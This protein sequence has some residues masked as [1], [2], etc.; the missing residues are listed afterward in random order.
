MSIR[1]AA[2]LPAGL[3]LMSVAVGVFSRW[4]IS[5]QAAS[6]LITGAGWACFSHIIYRQLVNARD[7]VE[8]NSS[9]SVC[10]RTALTAGPLAKVLVGLLFIHLSLI[11]ANS[12]FR[13]IFPWDAVTTWMYS[14]KAWVMSDSITELVYAPTWLSKVDSLGHPM[15]ASHYPQTLPKHTAALSA[16]SGVWRPLVPGLTWAA[17]WIAIILMTGGAIASASGSPPIALIGAYMMGSL[18]LLNAHAALAGYADI[19]MVLCSGGGLMML[20]VWSQ[21]K[22]PQFLYLSLMLLLAG[23][24]IKAEGWIWA[25]MG[26]VFLLHQYFLGRR[27]YILM[28]LFFGLSLASMVALDI[29]EISLGPAGFW[30]FSAD[31]IS[32]GVLGS[33]PTRPYNALPNYFVALVNEPNFHL[34]GIVYLASLLVISFKL[35]R[36]AAPFWLMSCLII[37]S[38]SII[39][40][41]SSFSEYAES[42]TAINRLLLHFVPVFVFTACMGLKLS[43]QPSKSPQSF[44]SPQ[45]TAVLAAF[46][47]LSICFLVVMHLTLSGSRTPAS[48]ASFQA[49]DMVSVLGETKMED[50]GL[51]FLK[52]NAP[53]GVLRAPSTRPSD[54]NNRIAH[55]E[56]ASDDRQHV[57]FYWIN[58]E[59]RAV[60]HSVAPG[61]A[62]NAIIDLSVEDSWGKEAIAEWGVITLSE[63]FETTVVKRVS[64]HEGL[65]PSLIPELFKYWWSPR[66]PNQRS[67][68]FLHRQ[69][70][71]FPSASTVISAA[72][73]ICLLLGAVASI[74]FRRRVNAWAITASMIGVLWIISD[75]LWMR[76]LTYWAGT[77]SSL[78]TPDQTELINSGDRAEHMARAIRKAIPADQDALI[79]STSKE[80]EFEASKLPYLLLPRKAAVTPLAR[81]QN[82]HHDSRAIVLIGTDVAISEIAENII[83]KNSFMLSADNSL[84][85]MRVLLP[86]NEL[87]GQQD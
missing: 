75:L 22:T 39:F 38:Q 6:W 43:L 72:A 52:T 2:S 11:L 18:P 80:L 4:G 28:L 76:T 71:S 78:L 53:V 40:G 14:S 29:T 42:G 63:G 31:Q 81:L 34:L 41:L 66:G 35:R 20:L 44:A 60:V 26:G 32:V 7:S 61:V 36:G 16:L 3:V 56:L 17:C 12:A 1:V 27:D 86:V 30:G 49:E 48:T 73:A 85:N 82:S 77:A 46:A 59:D 47:A 37:G 65:S 70:E 19:W 62:G 58:K 21:L 10:L 57:K 69:R 45:R 23:A 68:N 87:D 8:A 24:V 79:I 67:L 25:G 51:M 83:A 84:E 33:Y 13:P 74:L 55:L 9:P 54:A 64:L 50:G 5:L 15:Y